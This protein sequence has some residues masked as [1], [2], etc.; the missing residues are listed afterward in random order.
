MNKFGAIVLFTII[1]LV[2]ANILMTIAL[3]KSYHELKIQVRAVDQTIKSTQIRELYLYNLAKAMNPK[4]FEDDQ[5]QDNKL[6][7]DKKPATN[8][9]VK[10]QQKPAAGTD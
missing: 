9:G 7:K 10:N 1:L 6:L 5:K 3:I 4:L 8:Q 2:I